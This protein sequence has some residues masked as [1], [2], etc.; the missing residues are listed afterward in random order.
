MI[1]NTFLHKIMKKTV[2]R[3][4]RKRTGS[5]IKMKRS[6]ALHLF[7]CMIQLIKV[8]NPGILPLLHTVL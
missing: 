2:I 8:Y 4:V 3:A 6:S 7:V 1:P 5:L